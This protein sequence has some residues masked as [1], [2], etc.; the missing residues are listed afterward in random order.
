MQGA[1]TYGSRMD[2]PGA[3]AGSTGRGMSHC[4]GGRGS[5]GSGSQRG[6]ISTVGP[7]CSGGRDPHYYGGS[8]TA[9]RSAPK[10]LHKMAYRELQQ[11]SKRAGLGA[12]GNTKHW[13]S[14]SRVIQNPQL[15]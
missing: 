14:N 1:A 12:T 11:E 8:V 3:I 15:N 13:C 9:G 4:R 5:L 7:G 6:G 10:S 2:S